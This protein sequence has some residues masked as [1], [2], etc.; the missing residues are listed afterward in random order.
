MSSQ[1]VRG[2]F[3]GKEWPGEDTPDRASGRP[4]SMH[5]DESGEYS[6]DVEK[7]WWDYDIMHHLY[8]EEKK[9]IK[10]IAEIVG[11]SFSHVQ[12][13]LKDL[14]IPARSKSE[15][16]LA[17]Y[18]GVRLTFGNKGHERWTHLS[19]TI[20]VHRLAA[21]AC[22]GKDAVIGKEV[23][24]K[25]GIGWDT[26]EDNLELLTKSEHKSQYSKLTWETK[27]EIEDRYSNEEGASTHTLAEDY[28]VSSST[29]MRYVREVRGE[30]EAP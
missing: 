13:C 30:K 25:N 8:I 28:P 9:S 16:L 15:G 11:C 19:K 27:V 26:R 29:I 5:K 24:H 17:R 21:V 10:E 12:S 22:F 1:E 4:E 23:H 7:P 20:E 18:P 6:F 14:G 2:H 3:E